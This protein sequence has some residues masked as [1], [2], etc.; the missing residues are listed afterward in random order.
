MP[1]FVSTV[2][3]FAAAFRALY[4][5]RQPSFFSLTAALPA[6]G[7]TDTPVAATPRLTVVVKCYAGTGENAL[8]AHT[9][10][11]H[12]F[13]V[14]QGRAH[15]FGPNEEQRTV[16]ALGGVMMPVGTFYRFCAAEGEPLVMLRVGCAAAPQGSMYDRIGPDGRAMAGDSK[17]NNPLATVLSGEVFG[18]SNGED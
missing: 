1:P 10:E 7:R 12:V 15:F 17:E 14:L 8:H 6:V 11:D 2:E 13:I 3:E 9:T 4:R 5:E 16:E 18:P